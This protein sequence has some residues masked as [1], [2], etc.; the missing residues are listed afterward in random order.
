MEP[1]HSTERRPQI[2]VPD[3]CPTHLSLLVHGAGYRKSD[4]WQALVLV[5]QIALLRG[6]A[7]DPAIRFRCDDDLSRISD[8]GCL[9]CQKPDCF[10]EIV[11][12]AKSHDLDAVKRLGE[13]W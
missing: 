12:V 3:L 10:G 1:I 4:P 9:G 6:A 2:R 13:S 8:L 7:A 11:E 5:A